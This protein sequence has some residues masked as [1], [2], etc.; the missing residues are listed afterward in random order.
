[1]T[2]YFKCDVQYCKD[3]T[4]CRSVE[5]KP[6]LSIGD[7]VR[8]SKHISQDIHTLWQTRG[9]LNLGP[10]NE[11]SSEVF[12]LELGFRHDPCPY[13]R[14]NKC[15]IYPVR[16]VTCA[17]FPFLLQ[18]TDN[19]QDYP[20][21]KDKKRNA[22][23]LEFASK[24]DL[25]R[26]EEREQ[27]IVK[28]GESYVQAPQQILLQR[29]YNFAAKKATGSIHMKRAIQASKRLLKIVQ[30]GAEIHADDYRDLVGRI[31]NPK[32]HELIG[33]SLKTITEHDLR[34]IEAT[35]E[36]YLALLREFSDV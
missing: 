35:T 5:N 26:Y 16:P 24:L 20:C 34:K 27:T 25:I 8:I 1:M 31:L 28:L 22:R 23:Q 11:T 10:I 3:A 33:L 17:G 36:E 15:G 18:S 14:S 30:T 9:E 6:G 19:W 12:N 29:A 2:A 21:L 7:L 32:W 13:L 4:C